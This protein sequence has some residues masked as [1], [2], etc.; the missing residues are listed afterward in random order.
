MDWGSSN[1]STS[2][3]G[4]EGRK[5]E[6]REREKGTKSKSG[7]KALSIEAMSEMSLCVQDP[8]EILRHEK[9]H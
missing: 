4:G 1:P 6:K 5:E 2:G 3:G 9:P 7:G 8:K